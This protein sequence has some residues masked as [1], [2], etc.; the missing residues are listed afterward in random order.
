[1]AGGSRPGAEGVLTPDG[2]KGQYLT[3]VRD[4]SAI[5]P[6]TWTLDA[7]K[8]NRPGNKDIQLDLLLDYGSNP[9]LY[10]KWQESFRTSQPPM[11]IVWG[12]N[13]RIF[14]P[15]GAEPYKRDIKDLEYHLLDT[16]HFAFRP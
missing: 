7:A 5:G 12:K 16:G 2:Y 1:M 13:D 6:D 14:R 8:L 3:G 9:L 10:P 11:L 4:P 15:S